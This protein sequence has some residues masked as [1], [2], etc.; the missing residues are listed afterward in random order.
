MRLI[1]GVERPLVREKLHGLHHLHPAHARHGVDEQ[2][3]GR[4]HSVDE[5]EGGRRRSSTQ[6]TQSGSQDKVHLVC[7]RLL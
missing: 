5:Q 2:E 3:G 6:G 4:R 7:V 1:G